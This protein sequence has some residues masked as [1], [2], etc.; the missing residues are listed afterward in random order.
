ML[1][2][3]YY[4]AVYVITGVIVVYF[5][6]SSFLPLVIF[7]L[8]WL[9]LVPPVLCRLVISIFG[10]PVGTV[11]LRTG[12]FMYW[13][14]L[15]QLQIIYVRFQLL[16]EL[17]RLF[18]GI[19]SLWLNL[20]GGKVSLLAYWAPGVTVTDYYHINIGKGA[21]IGGGCRIGGH[22]FTVDKDGSQRLIVA[23]LTIEDNS[24]IGLN[25]AVGPGSHVHANETIP[26]GKML[27]PF[28]SWKNGKVQRPA[29]NI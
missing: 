16:E 3:N 20:W 27:K 25:A 12:L 26:A 28:H 7:V 11:G 18:P 8:S 24:L 21:V 4:S 5:L 10:R 22:V 15:T 14:F 1:A 9:Y 13:W 2:I 29:A 19:Y 17:L 6:L 23:P